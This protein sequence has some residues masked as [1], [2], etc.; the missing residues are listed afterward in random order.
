[1]SD[2]LFVE[3]KDRERKRLVSLSILFL[4]LKNTSPHWAWLQHKNPATLAILPFQCLHGRLLSTS[5]V[6]DSKNGAQPYLIT[7]T[8]SN[9]LRALTLLRTWSRKL[10]IEVASWYQNVMNLKACRVCNEGM[11]ED[12]CHLLFTYSTYSAIH[13]RYVDI[14]RGSVNLSAIL[15]TPPRRLSSC[16]PYSRIETCAS[17]CEYPFLGRRHITNTCILWSHRSKLASLCTIIFFLNSLSHA[18]AFSH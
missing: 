8:S 2:H 17:M 6:G 15:K 5:S 1:M 3:T 11:V 18:R 13:S 16:V 4:L 7:N 12:E 9:A 10:S 14:L